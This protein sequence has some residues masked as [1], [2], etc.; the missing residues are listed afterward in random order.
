MKVTEIQIGKVYRGRGAGRTHRRVVAIG[1]EY[2]PCQWFGDPDKKPMEHGVLF[3][4]NGQHRRLFIS[5]FAHW[6]GSEVIDAC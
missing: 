3:E 1:Y 6:V 4:Q 2:R 5:S